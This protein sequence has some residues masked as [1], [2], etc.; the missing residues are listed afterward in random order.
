MQI[1]QR[2][3]C[4]YLDAGYSETNSPTSGD[5][6]GDDDGIRRSD[7]S[8]R[9]GLHQTACPVCVSRTFDVLG[10]Y[11]LCHVI[12]VLCRPVGV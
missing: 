1:V 8:P 4:Y 2:H 3:L 7:D 6:S 11:V 12:T 9:Q 5:E 10:D